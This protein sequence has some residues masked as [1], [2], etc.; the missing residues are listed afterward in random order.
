MYAVTIYIYLLIP[1]QGNGAGAN[2]YGDR[3]AYT[4]QQNMSIKGQFSSSI[5]PK[6]TAEYPHAQISPF[7]VR[8]GGSRRRCPQIN[9]RFL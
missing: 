9:S 8:N 6:I 7:L 4:A 3:L 2:V 1:L 5:L